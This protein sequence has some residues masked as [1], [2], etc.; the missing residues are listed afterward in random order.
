[1]K[2]TLPDAD[3]SDEIAYLGGLREIF[4]VAGDSMLPALKDGD[5]VLIDRRAELETG[6]IV[7]ARHPFRQ[8]VKIIKR[9][10]EILPG[11]KYFLLSDNPDEGTDS[12]SFGAISA[13]DILGKAG[14]RIKPEDSEK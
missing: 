8:S 5:L 2:K 10:A 1:M 3:E 7:L 12:R 9:I 4:R 14:A 6:D 11:E 13:K